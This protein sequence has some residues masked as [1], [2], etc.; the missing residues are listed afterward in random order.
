MISGRDEDWQVFVQFELIFL[1]GVWFLSGLAPPWARISALT[2]IIGILACDVL[3]AIAGVPPRHAFAQVLVGSWWIMASDMIV[4]VALFRWRPSSDRATWIESHPLGLVLIT[5]LAMVLGIA[6]DRSQIGRFPMEATARSGGASSSPGLDYL[7]YLP[8]GY[9][10]SRR[11]WP[12][13]LDLHG[14]GSSGREVRRVRTGGLPRRIDAGL[15][16]P[17]I[18][19]AP[20]SPKHGWEPEPLDTLLTEV[21]ERYR[22]DP[23][24]VYLTGSSMGGYGVW[25]LATAHPQRFAA[26]APIC[27]GGDPA[28]AERLRTVPT[29]A[30]H[31]SDD[32]IIPADE[33]RKM[34]AAQERSGGEAKLTIYPGVGHDAATPTYTDR[35]LYDWML[36]HRRRIGRAETE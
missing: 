2:A 21:I 26:I 31:G 7:V 8:D 3:R 23:E 34:I 12:L 30:F 35:K 1:G 32:T 17:F 22:V 10:L 11:R 5:A 33:S 14:A 25:A 28:A 13:I 16:L 19:V 36:A 4:I 27:G 20:Q 6:I 24:R 15:R 18:I 9:H 29:W